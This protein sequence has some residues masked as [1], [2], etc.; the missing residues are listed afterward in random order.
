[1]SIRLFSGDV[2]EVG[3]SLKVKAVFDI[4]SDTEIWNGNISLFTKLP[5]GNE[6]TVAN[7]NIFCEGELKK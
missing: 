7:S 2:A 3:G 4:D 1:M 5:C 6:L